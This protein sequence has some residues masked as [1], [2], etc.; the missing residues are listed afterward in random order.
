ACVHCKSLKVK[1]E[2][3]PGQRICERCRNNGHKCLD[4][5]RKKR[6]AAPTQ[7][8]LQQQSKSQDDRISELLGLLEAAK[9][10][11]KFRQRLSKDGRQ[12]DGYCAE[13]LSESTEPIAV[14]SI[15]ECNLFQ[16][17]EISELFKTFFLRVNSYFSILDPDLHTPERLINESP[18]L[19]TVICTTACRYYDGARDR[20]D[21][22]MEFAE[23]AAGSALVDQRKDVDM[24]QAY[25]LMAVYPNPKKKWDQ[26]TSW[27][28][29]G[30]AIRLA[31]EL[32]LNQPPPPTIAERERL[33][34]TRTWLNCFCVDASHATQYGKPPMVN[35]TDDFIACQSRNS[36]YKESPLNLLYDIHLC[37]Y[38]DILLLMAKFR[39]IV[40]HSD[41]SQR[42]KN[43]LDI[44]AVATR[45]DGELEEMIDAWVRRYRDHESNRDEICRYRGNTTRL[46]AAYSRL[47]V[48][49]LGFQ[50]ASE[51][52]SR[53]HPIVTRCVEVAKT[54]IKIMTESLF[55]TPYLRYSMAAHFLYVA[56]AAAFLLNLMRPSLLHLIDTNQQSDI[57]ALVSQLI[58]ILGSE[59]VALDGRHTP[60]LYSRFLSTLLAKHCPTFPP[61]Q[62]GADGSPTNEF[63]PQYVAD[64]QQTPP[65]TH[66]W[67][68]SFSN[69][70]PAMDYVSTPPD[71]IL[72]SDY[73][74]ITDFS[75]QNFVQYNNPFG[76]QP[77]EPMQTVASWEYPPFDS[78][79]FEETVYSNFVYNPMQFN[80]DPLRT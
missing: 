25:L 40:G 14:P 15:I 33:N 36:W 31:M 43:G 70:L 78:T 42:I 20:H 65:Y 32:D 35:L 55:R 72:G 46:I 7:E 30:L 56:F 26:D 1:C 77:A 34:R 45:F 53:E 75:L 71:E 38:V 67:P 47:V 17:Q 12:M 4:R 63:V 57:V 18:F 28:L 69:Q 76:D 29:I 23:D 8:E 60:A 41:L 5:E 19:F 58:E 27:R 10:H 21:V 73:P 49:S 50:Y 79:A 11:E 44:I 16:H 59:Q 74:W 54:V 2:P 64:R 61:E 37:G 80:P 24:C 52:L 66:S 51:T 39:S 62:N 68:E 48:L 6:K 3:I 22:A 9:L 13:Y